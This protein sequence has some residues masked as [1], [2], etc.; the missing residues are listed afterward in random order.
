MYTLMGCEVESLNDSILEVCFW[1]SFGE[2]SLLILTT[3]PH[4][5]EVQKPEL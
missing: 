3:W 2:L 1:S 4:M 5:N